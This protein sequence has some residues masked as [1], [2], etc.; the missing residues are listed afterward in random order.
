MTV[1]GSPVGRAI[2]LATCSHLL[3]GECGPGREPHIVSA[4][5]DLDGKAVQL[6]LNIDGLG[7]YSAVSA[8]IISERLEPIQGYTAADCTAPISSG[9]SQ[10]VVWQGGDALPHDLGPIRV[11]INF[12]GVRVEDI[13]L[14]AAYLTSARN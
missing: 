11:R 7:E 1:C 5:I 10:P 9:L 13:K 4:P 8:E 14:Y 6:A 12:S 2:G 3:P